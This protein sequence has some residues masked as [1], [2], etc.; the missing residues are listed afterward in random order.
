MARLS[1]GSL[2]LCHIFIPPPSLTVAPVSPFLCPLKFAH[3][4]SGLKEHLRPLSLPICP[5]P[6]SLAPNVGDDHLFITGMNK[7]SSVFRHTNN[8]MAE[9]SPDLLR[10][11]L[12]RHTRRR[13]TMSGKLSGST[14]RQSGNTGWPR[15]QSRTRQSCCTDALRFLHG[16]THYLVLLVF[17]GRRTSNASF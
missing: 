10:V 5:M 3:Q 15:K 9:F 7:R 2:C 1:V 4:P 12:E 8:L 14:C 17:T 6:L 11:S 13:H 16:R